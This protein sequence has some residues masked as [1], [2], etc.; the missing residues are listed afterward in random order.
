MSNVFSKIASL[1]GAS[2]EDSN[3]LLTTAFLC[4][5]QTTSNRTPIETRTENSRQ[6]SCMFF[7]H[8]GLLVVDADIYAYVL[9]PSN[10]T[11]VCWSCSAVLDSSPCQD[12][13]SSA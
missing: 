7:S 8:E 6:I 10:H 13:S 1:I 3:Q 12:Y 2:D 9:D 11:S 4:N 5:K